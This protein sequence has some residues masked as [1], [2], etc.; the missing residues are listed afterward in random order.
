ME[1]DSIKVSED[2]FRNVFT[3]MI[4]YFVENFG[5]E[6]ETELALTLKD[7]VNRNRQEG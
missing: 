4:V 2:Y 7:E 5:T 1:T 6:K 3:Q